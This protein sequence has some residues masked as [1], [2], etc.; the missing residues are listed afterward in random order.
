VRDILAN[1]RRTADT[2]NLAAQRH[3]VSRTIAEV[4]LPRL[5][6]HWHLPLGDENF[7][8]APG[9]ANK[10]EQ[11]SV[12]GVS[13]NW[14]LPKPGSLQKVGEGA[15][16]FIADSTAEAKQYLPANNN[17]RAKTDTVQPTKR[18]TRYSTMP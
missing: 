18:E 15:K 14:V 11:T 3:T 10:L 2:P 6:S 5:S 13:D 4:P 1:R 12:D 7:T 8:A 17:G 16:A 9:E